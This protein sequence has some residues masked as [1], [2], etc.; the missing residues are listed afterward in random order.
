MKKVYKWELHTDYEFY[1]PFDF[2]VERQYHDEKGRV[3]LTVDGN[4]CI[5]HK[6]Y[7]WDGCSPK[8]KVG[9]KLI[10]VYDGK[11]IFHAKML[12]R[13]QQLKYASLVHDCFY[14]FYDSFSMTISK[15]KIDYLFYLDCKA[16][17]FE[18]SCLYYQAVKHLG[19]KYTDGRV[20]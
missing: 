17:G 1:A 15:E 8:F 12:D 19:T 18:L 3:W 16:T 14:Q 13:D 9:N 6:G 2:G 4:Y 7:C 10:G 5:I 20:K 11:E